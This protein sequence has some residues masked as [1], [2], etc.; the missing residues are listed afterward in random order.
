MGKCGWV[1]ATL[2][3]ARVRQVWSILS[4]SDTLKHQAK[5]FS[6]E[7]I[8]LIALCW[9]L[10]PWLSACEAGALPLRCS[11]LRWWL[12]I[13]ALTSHPPMALACSNN[14][15]L[16]QHKIRHPLYKSSVPNQAGIHFS[17][18]QTKSSSCTLS[19]TVSASCCCSR[20]DKVKMLFRKYPTLELSFQHRN[21]AFVLL[22]NM[23]P[24]Q[25][26]HTTKAARCRAADVFTVSQAAFSL[27]ASASEINH[28]LP[29][30]NLQARA[31]QMAS[32]CHR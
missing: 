8:C 23:A 9:S 13:N 12:S 27:L 6:S 16:R 19:L 1:G 4:S 29:N 22:P 32:W 5:K 24:A 26:T 30:S 2:Q 25:H 18:T 21:Q 3:L 17:Y 15:M 20:A 7:P 10:N 31:V 14:N 28:T 11:S